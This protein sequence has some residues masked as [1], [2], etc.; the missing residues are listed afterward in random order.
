MQIKL[1]LNDLGEFVRTT[2]MFESDIDIRSINHSKSI[3]AKSIISLLSIDFNSP[4]QVEINSPDK[5]EIERFEKEMEKYIAN[6]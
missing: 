5:D 4:L 6:E 2:E 1:G 3:D